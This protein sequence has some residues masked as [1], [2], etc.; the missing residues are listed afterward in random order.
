MKMG[1]KWCL[2]PWVVGLAEK[3]KGL[4]WTR[5]RV[6]HPG[7]EETGQAWSDQTKGFVPS[8]AEHPASAWH[9]IQSR[10]GWPFLCCQQISLKPAGETSR[11]STRPVHKKWRQEVRI[12]V[13]AHCRGWSKLVQTDLLLTLPK[14]RLL[15]RSGLLMFFSHSSWE[16]RIGMAIFD[17]FP[18]KWMCS[19]INYE[20]VYLE[21]EFLMPLEWILI[22]FT[23]LVCH[24]TYCYRRKD[25]E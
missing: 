23:D 22:Q 11:P 17:F 2:T 19:Y 18:K 1:R 25:Q 4:G 16:G 5:G 24:S 6:S 3:A 7:G 9:G 13:I 8:K 14:G 21:N 12:A 20:Y 15:H 10:W